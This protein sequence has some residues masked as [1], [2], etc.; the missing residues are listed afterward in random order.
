MEVAR[1]VYLLG[2]SA[3]QAPSLVIT[4]MK[5][6]EGALILVFINHSIGDTA[7]EDVSF[8]YCLNQFS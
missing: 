8:F 3:E 1:E 7:S 4:P 5:E 2:E 6:K